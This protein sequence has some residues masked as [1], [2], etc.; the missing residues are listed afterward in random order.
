MDLARGLRRRVAGDRHPDGR[1]RPVSRCELFDE[2]DLDAAL[3]RF[4]ELHPQARRLEN[5]ASRVAERFLA[6]F[7]ARDWDAMAEMLADDYFSDD[8][9]RVVGAGVRHG[10]DAEIADMRAI[11]DLG[12]TNVTST[13]IATRGE[14]LASRAPATRAAIKSPTRSARMHLPSARST[15][16]SR[17]A[18]VVVFDVDDIDAAFEELDARYLA[19]EAAA[20]SRT[21]SV[22]AGPMPRST[23]A[24]SPRRRRTGSTSTIRRSQR[25]E[26]GDLAAIHPCHVGSHADISIHIEAVHQAEQPRSGRHPDGKWDLARRL[27]RRVAAGRHVHRRGDMVNRCE[28]FDETDIDAALARFEELHPQAPRLENAASQS[29]D[30]LLGATSRPATGTR[31]PRYWPTTFARDDRRRV[32]NAGVRRGR[33][34]ISRTCAQWPTSDSRT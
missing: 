23:G 33:M 18:A 27:R 16:T 19:G 11:A 28:V 2:A 32:V 7:A 24:N 25:I 30:T 3:A 14:R 17:I 34:P 4:E 22:I 12:I 9:R 5:A 1:G 29:V 6:Q 31:W 10:R 8:R 21:W 26:P 13:V 20:H 15:P